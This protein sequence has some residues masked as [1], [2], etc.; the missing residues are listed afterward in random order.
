MVDG[1]FRVAVLSKIHYSNS[2]KKCKSH[3]LKFVS[4][5]IRGKIVRQSAFCKINL[6]DPR[7][8][9]CFQFFRSVGLNKVTKRCFIGAYLATA[10]CFLFPKNFRFSQGSDFVFVNSTIFLS[11]HPVFRFFLRTTTWTYFT[12]SK[13][14]FV[15][16]ALTFNNLQ[17]TRHL[18]L[19]LYAYHKLDILTAQSATTAT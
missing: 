17:H 3:K 13:N 9:F 16:D 18:Y 1:R 10:L 8:H 5:V 7:F 19:E 11:S 14:F 15:D 2:S 6:A 12:Q 4:I